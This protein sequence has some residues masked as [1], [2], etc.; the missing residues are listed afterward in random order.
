MLLHYISQLMVPSKL[1]NLLWILYFKN[2]INY[3]YRKKKKKKKK[4]LIY[5]KNY[6]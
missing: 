6:S 3:S 1:D 2:Y 5:N 4:S